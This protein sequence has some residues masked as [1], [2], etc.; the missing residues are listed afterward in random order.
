MVVGC[1]IKGM[2][3]FYTSICPNIQPNPGGGVHGDT[4]VSST[5]ARRSGAIEEKPEDATLYKWGW[6]LGVAV[7]ALTAVYRYAG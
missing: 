4:Y 3:P 2:A 5:N 6:L 1:I 7:G